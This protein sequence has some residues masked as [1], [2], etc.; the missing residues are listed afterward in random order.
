MEVQKSQDDDNNPG[1]GEGIL[2]GSYFLGYLALAFIIGL[3]LT[4]ILPAYFAFF[5]SFVSLDYAFF[6]GAHFLW[7]KRM[8][9]FE[10]RIVHRLLKAN[11]LEFNYKE[12]IRDLPHQESV[13]QRAN[14]EDGGT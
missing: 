4:N 5:V 6:I 8:T 14:P 11:L 2:I 1:W 12:D 13:I 7:T 9:R 10:G 3:F